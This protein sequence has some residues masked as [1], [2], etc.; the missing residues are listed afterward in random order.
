MIVNG[1]V[2]NG[3]H[4]TSSIVQEAAGDPLTGSSSSLN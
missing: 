2:N 1:I 3:V 4:S